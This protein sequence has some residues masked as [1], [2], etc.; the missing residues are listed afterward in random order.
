MR[1]IFVNL[2]VKDLAAT[3]R[4][5]SALGFGFNEA[6]S[7]DT[8]ACMVVD[9]N[10]FVMHLTEE[11]FAHFVKGEVGDPEKQTQVLTCLSAASRQEVDDFKAKALAAGGREWQP[12]IEFGPMYGCSFQ[13]ISGNVWEFMFMDQS[14]G[15][16]IG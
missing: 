9:A 11:K 12:N 4:F 6:F 14:G 1:M 15:Q 5:F 16:S 10:I 13:D 2:P 3:R 7:D 8:A